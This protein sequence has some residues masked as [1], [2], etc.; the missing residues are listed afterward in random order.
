MKFKLR[1]HEQV[2]IL[3]IGKSCLTVCVCVCVRVCVRA[4]VCTLCG[5]EVESTSKDVTF[6]SFLF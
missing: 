1:C 6:G 2:K 3:R 5:G 4:Y